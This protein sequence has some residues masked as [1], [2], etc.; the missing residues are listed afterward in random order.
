LRNSQWAAAYLFYPHASASSSANEF[1]MPR[2]Q[3][4]KHISSHSP[5][6]TLSSSPASAGALKSMEMMPQPGTTAPESAS[7]AQQ[8]ARFTRR[9]T[10]GAVATPLKNDTTDSYDGEDEPYIG[11]LICRHDRDG[12]MIGTVSKYLPLACNNSEGEMWR[13]L[14][15]DG[16]SAWIDRKT[17]L[18]WQEAYANSY[19]GS[20]A[21]EDIERVDASKR[22]TQSTQQVRH[23]HTSASASLPLP[24]SQ[25]STRTKRCVQ[26][27]GKT[28]D[29]NDGDL[30]SGL[31]QPSSFSCPA[32]GLASS[33]SIAVDQKVPLAK[34]SDIRHDADIDGPT[35]KRPRYGEPYPTQLDV[36]TNLVS[37]DGLGEDCKPRQASFAASCG[38]HS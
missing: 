8:I 13:I 4:S 38:G 29:Q 28:P 36:D 17:L 23:L 3:S 21:T 20:T 18:G 33:I 15:S 16:S 31:P 6:V 2:I 12:K 1:P 27:H 30:L 37:L 14:F 35:A 26:R 11:V 7:G 19:P 22:G 34:H 9:C 24:S 25:K 5:L 10:V 32:S